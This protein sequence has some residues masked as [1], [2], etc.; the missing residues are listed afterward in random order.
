M[1]VVEAPRE[2]TQPL[3]GHTARLWCSV[4][5]GAAGIRGFSSTCSLI[6]VWTRWAMASIILLAVQRALTVL[7]SLVI[8]LSLI[9][10]LGPGAQFPIGESGPSDAGRWARRGSGAGPPG[11]FKEHLGFSI[12]LIGN[13]I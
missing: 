9:A 6:M 7:V 11:P 10:L 8:L 5:A 3:R 12:L 2:V 1:L 4:Q 13:L